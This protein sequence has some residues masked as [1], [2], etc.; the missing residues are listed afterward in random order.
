MN[1]SIM[2]MNDLMLKL[3]PITDINTPINTKK[4]YHKKVNE[5]KS[6]YEELKK[7][8]DEFFSKLKKFNFM[9][10]PTNSLS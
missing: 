6:L 10:H 2:K 5:I 4:T 8:T 9:Q 1:D 3:T 7:E